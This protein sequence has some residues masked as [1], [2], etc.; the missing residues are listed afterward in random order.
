MQRK[1]WMSLVVMSLDDKCITWHISVDNYKI[2]FRVSTAFLKIEECFF[3]AR[4]EV[5]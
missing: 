4:K 5:D 2:K 3:H 1:P